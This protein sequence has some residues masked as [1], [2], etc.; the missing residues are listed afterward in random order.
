MQLKSGL[1]AGRCGPERA[2]EVHALTRAAFASQAAL[3]PPSGAVRE[4][5]E[6]VRADLAAGCGV[7][8]FLDHRP[9]AAARLLF[10][11][12]HT[13]VRRVAVDPAHQRR[14]V[15][16]ALMEWIHGDLARAGAR[17][18]RL[19]V[20]KALA[21]QRAF[22]ERLGYEEVSDEGFWVWLGRPLAPPAT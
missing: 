11:D 13:V 4:T 2:A 15:G 5:I 20:R 6:V 17:E 8:A 14:G 9:V 1:V 16:R 21:T 19:G 22:S 12:A 10:E 7:L 18:V 3:D